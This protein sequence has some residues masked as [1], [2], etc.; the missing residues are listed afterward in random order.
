MLVA[1]PLVAR[2]GRPGGFAV[3]R[4]ET[5]VAV[6]LAAVAAIGIV[7]AARTDVWTRGLVLRAMGV[8][9]RR[10]LVFTAAVALA[11]GGQDAWVVAVAVLAGFPI[12]YALRGVFP[13]S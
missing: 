8:C 9:L 12:S 11:V 6:L 10:L 4:T 7:R 1:A 5:V 3:A 2:I 13:P